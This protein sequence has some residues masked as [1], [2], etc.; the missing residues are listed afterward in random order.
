[1]LTCG[2]VTL[3]VA[4]R[5]RQFLPEGSQANTLESPY[6]CAPSLTAALTL[7]AAMEEAPFGGVGASGMGHYHGRDGFLEFSHART[8]F[9]GAPVD[10][11]AEWGMLP[12]FPEHFAAAMAAQVTR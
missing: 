6:A 1:M 12:P 7:H 8:V 9:Q 2:A 3:P 10:P 11:R 4:V 5:T